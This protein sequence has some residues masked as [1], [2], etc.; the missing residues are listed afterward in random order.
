[1]LISALFLATK[2]AFDNNPI[3]KVPKMNNMMKILLIITICFGLSGVSNATVI[4]DFDSATTG[5]DI[6]A[7]PLVTADGTI[8]ASASNGTLSYLGGGGFRG[9][10]F[11]FAESTDGGFAQLAFDYD[12][13]SV[14]FLFAGFL[15][16]VFT[17]EVL[18]AAFNVIDTFFDD[19]TSNDRP[20]GP[21]ML[22]GA[23]IRYFRFSD[24][25]GGLSFA[26]VDDIT[27]EAATV[28]EPS[29][30]ALFALALIGFMVSRK[31]VL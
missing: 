2:N 14:T 31:K 4:L 1:M 22:S 28:S 24:S 23:D 5:S 25:P 9:N 6:I 18:D 21:I 11:R 15:S 29:T 20:G 13:T 7:S 19:D 30:L 3:W 26:G 17:G 16:G 8:T 27:I 10:G 12:V